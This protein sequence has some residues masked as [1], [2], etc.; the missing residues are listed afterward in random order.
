MQST[1]NNYKILFFNPAL[2]INEQ[3]FNKLTLVTNPIDC[4]HEATEHTYDLVVIFHEYKS[5]KERDTL[6]ELCSTLKR[7]TYTMHTPFLLLLPSRHRKLLEHLRDAGVEYAVFYD[8]CDPNLKNHIETLL[9][10]PPKEC[11]IEKILADI[12]PY[13]NYIPTSR[14]K[15]ISYCG[16]YRN[17]LVLG[18]Y[19]LRHLCEISD[20]KICQYFN[21]PRFF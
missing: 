13:I 19:R 3:L 16:A 9:K 11:A 17:R 14:H 15:E 12:C 2:N 1:N 6:I 10:D 8:P 18:S 20:H 7:N 21:C 4:F 5:V